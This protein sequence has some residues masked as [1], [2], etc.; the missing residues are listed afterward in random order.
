MKHLAYI[1][2]A[3]SLCA[4]VFAS[5]KDDEW[6]YPSND[7]AI[8]ISS[9]HL[10]DATDSVADRTVQY[11]RLGQLLRIEGSGLLGMRQ[12]YINGVS[13]YFNPTMLSNTS[14]IV[15]VPGDAPTVEADEAVRNKIRFVKSSGELTFDF[16][17]RPS[18]PTVTR[19]SHTMPQA[20]EKIYLYGTNLFEVSEVVFPGNKVVTENIESDDEE[21]TFCSVIVPAGVTASGALLVKGSAGAAYSPRY[22]NFREGLL[23]SFDE[24]AS[25]AAWSSGLISNDTATAIPATGSE[26]KSQGK[27]RIFNK[28]ATAIP[29]STIDAG[30]YWSNSTDWAAVLTESV[31]PSTT[32]TN[33][34]AVQMDIYVEGE[35]SSGTI[36]MV[37]A[38]GAGAQRYCMWY[39][40]WVVNGKKVPFVN[41]GGWFT[42]TLPFSDSPDFV[43]ANTKAPLTFAEVSL[44]VASAGYKQWGPH[45]DNTDVTDNK[46][47]ATVI[48]AA[49]P[50]SVKIYFDNLRVVPLETPAYNE[51]AN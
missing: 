5:C 49:T 1:L 11:A 9:V 20:G 25:R 24:G 6:E 50:T 19:I 17:I 12:V 39:S 33:M 38:D 28:D 26:P 34:C 22:F 42:I 8:T 3:F 48:Q 47:P 41:P 4:L 15:R 7:E 40:P 16:E 14:M 35:W 44:R 45:F 27:Y 2:A 13:A 31:I 30:F 46:T 37:V 23:H 43:D 32:P 10:S 18:A 51:Y 36:R 29:V 21:G